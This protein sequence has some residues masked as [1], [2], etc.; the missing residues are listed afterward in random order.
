M[1]SV[2]DNVIALKKENYEL[3]KTDQET[4][5]LLSSYFKEAFTVEDTTNIPTVIQ[6]VFN[7]K[8]THLNFSTEIVMKKLRHLETDKSPGPDSIHPLLLKECAANAILAKP[9][10]LVFQHSY[11][12]GIL[13]D[14]WRTAHIV[15]IHIQERQQN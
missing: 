11:E 2:K 6:R 9:L 15:P 1:Q 12:T 14:K 5:D 13:P 7:W 10:S 8:D 3:T 4:A